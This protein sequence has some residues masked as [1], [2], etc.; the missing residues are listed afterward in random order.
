L[1]IEDNDFAL[2]AVGDE[3]AAKF[4]GYGDAVILFETGDGADGLAGVGVEDDDFSAVGDVSAAGGGIDGDVV[5]VL[6]GGAGAAGKG[7]FLRRW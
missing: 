4:G 2:A 3:A 6:A 5:E 7:Y 1:Q